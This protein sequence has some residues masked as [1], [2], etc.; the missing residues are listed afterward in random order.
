MTDARRILALEHLDQALADA[1]LT[2]SVPLPS[3]PG[4]RATAERVSAVQ[5]RFDTYFAQRHDY[6]KALA[7]VRGLTTMAAARTRAAEVAHRRLRR[8]LFWELVWK[9]YHIAFWVLLG[10]GISFAL[11][12]ALWLWRVEI[13]AFL[14]PPV[15]AAAP[16]AAVPVSAAPPVT[17]SGPVQPPQV[18]PSSPGQTPLITPVPNTAVPP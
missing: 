1:E 4:L 16:P 3:V 10:L 18:L 9:R 6:G 17:S 12:W 14:F 7:S 2:L 15:P 11:G 5:V 13:M 8:R